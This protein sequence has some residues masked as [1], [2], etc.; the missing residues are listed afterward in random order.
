MSMEVVLSKPF[1]VECCSREEWKDQKEPYSGHACLGQ[2][3]TNFQAK[4]CGILACINLGL[5]RHYYDRRIVIL[6]DCTSKL[7]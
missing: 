3:C 7:V 2:C 5:A 1:T 4:I 6:S